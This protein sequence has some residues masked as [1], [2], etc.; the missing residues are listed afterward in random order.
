MYDNVATLYKATETQDKYGNII[1]AYTTREVFVKPRSVYANEFY[2]AATVGLKPE[3]VIVLNNVKDY[4][5]EKM[6]L[7]SGEL[8]TVV[9][10]YQKPEKD[11]LELTLERRLGSA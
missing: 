9:R 10:T 11:A 2:N 1:E 7:F 6:V 3:L 8:Y 5:G 4:E